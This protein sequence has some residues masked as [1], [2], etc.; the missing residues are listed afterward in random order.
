MGIIVS[1][2]VGLVLWIILWAI[3]VKSLDAFLLTTVIIL[4]AAG[5]HVL[6]PHLPGRQDG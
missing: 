1:T 4:L 6:A 3:G 2:T 5:A